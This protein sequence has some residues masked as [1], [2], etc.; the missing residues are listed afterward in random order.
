[1]RH[2]AVLVLVGAC[3]GSAKPIA[4]QAPPSGAS[5]PALATDAPMDCTSTVEEA[6]P[7]NVDRY[8]FETPDGRHG[9]KNSKGQVVIAPTLRFG[10]EF[11]PG[12]IAAAVDADGHFVFIDASGKTIALAYPYDS[13]PDY[14]QEGYARIVDDAN[15]VGFISDHGIITVPP[16][17]DRAESFCHG[18]AEVTLG[19]RTLHINRLGVV[20]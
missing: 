2:L 17:Y 5:S 1:M 11:K 19:D 8:A 4:N 3:G 7:G 6:K 12:G 13:G 20:Q 14:F 16:T 10:Y 18:V 9:Y 15:K